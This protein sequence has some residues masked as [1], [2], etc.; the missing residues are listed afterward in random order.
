MIVSKNAV[1]KLL[2]CFGALSLFPKPANAMVAEFDVNPKTGVAMLLV[3]ARN[4]VHLADSQSQWKRYEFQ[5][6]LVGSGSSFFSGGSGDNVP[7]QHRGGGTPVF[8]SVL[9]SAGTWS[10][11]CRDYGTNPQGDTWNLTL[12]P[13]TVV[14][15]PSSTGTGGGGV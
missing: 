12:G 8:N 1:W 13:V 4:V 9:L 14:V 6:V 3:T 11:W 2:A 5:Y 7:P 15:D 10:C